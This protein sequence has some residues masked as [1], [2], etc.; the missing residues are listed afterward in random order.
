VALISNL[1]EAAEQLGIA[2]AADIA[3]ETAGLL[4]I[5]Q[6]VTFRHPLVR[7][8]VYRSADASERRAAH[9]ALAESTDPEVDP[10][11]RAWHL[12]AAAGP[13][14]NVAIEL[15]RSAV[16]AQARGGLAAAAAF[17][18]RTVALTG[19]P[20]RRVDR[21]LAAAEASLHAGAFDATSGLL[22]TAEMGSLDDLQQARLELL[23]GQMTFLATQGGDGSSLLLKAAQRLERL[24]L[25]LARVTY[26]DAWG[27]ALL[28][29]PN[30]ARSDLLD[31]SVAARSAPRPQ[32]PPRPANLLL[33]SLATLVTDGR[34][35]AAPLLE[36]AMRTFAD[37]HFP[38]DESLRWGW[39][40]VVPTFVLWDENS[41][42][43]ICRRQQDAV[44][45]AGALVSPVSPLAPPLD[46]R[47]GGL[48]PR[49]PAGVPTSAVRRAAIPGCGSSRGA[50]Q[51]HTDA[52]R[53]STRHAAANTN[54][55]TEV[56]MSSDGSHTENGQIPMILIHG[57]WLSARSWENYIDY[58]GKCGFAA[59]APS[60][61]ASKAMSRR[62]VRPARRRP[63]SGCRRSST[64]TSS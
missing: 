61:H 2:R 27:A 13:D 11:H 22:A 29:P 49:R 42:R 14:E 7:S 17:L 39:L 60:G 41:A 1:A 62:C 30:A 47:I 16:R 59:S 18:E 48:V 51:G 28:G 46:R 12:A 56:T 44:R 55:P 6:R 40:A 50:D 31:V 24:N 53:Q 10:D 9:R 21:A 20:A 54:R 3:A 8:A 26:L 38:A 35:A 37:E 43:A 33:D 58:F 34:A 19:D 25:E 5:G 52:T 45:E 57:A 15:E 63:A 32:G 23:R 36:E 64:I 4:A